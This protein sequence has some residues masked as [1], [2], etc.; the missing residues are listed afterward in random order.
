MRPDE[1][2]NDRPS[3]EF[4]IS[5]TIT[6]KVLEERLSLLSVDAQSDSRLSSDSIMI[7]HIHSVMCAPLLGKTGVL[8][9]IYVDKIDLRDTFGSDDLELLNAVASQ[10]AIAVDNAQAYEQLE[11]EAVARA[12]YQRFMPNNII[13]LIMES[14]GELR[15]GG[16]TQ[17]ATILF[18]DIR[19]FTPMAEKSP[20]EIVVNVLNRFFSAMTEIIF[21][22]LGTLDKYLGDG[23]M[24]IFGAP[25]QSEDDAIN[26][27]NAAIAMQR[28]LIKL[29]T[30]LKKLG[31]A[32]IEVGIG[33]NTGEVTV[34][35]V[36]SQRR[37]DYTAIG[38]AVNLSARL[39]QDAKGK[40]ILISESTYELLGQAFRT[41]Y[42]GE[43]NF[44]GGNNP[45]RVFQVIYN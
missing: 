27:V 20:P 17:S 34:G 4:T 18:A 25:Y 40:E 35:C 8:G 45:T 32:T 41:Q 15:L 11:I 2:K 39:M 13:D 31:F 23:L 24:A 43:Q 22:N 5:R 26:A 37:M 44:S 28:R 9:V 10:A 12:S 42:I 16:K 30:E 7:Q 19:G 6:A 1:K 21:A 38:S 36:G 3:G 33:I 14:P 29:N